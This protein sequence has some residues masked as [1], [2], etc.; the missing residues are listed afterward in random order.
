MANC[1]RLH[2]LHYYLKDISGLR[3]KHVEA[4]VKSWREDGLSNKTIQNNYSRLKIFCGWLGKEGIA[5]KDGAVHYLEEMGASQVDLRVKTVTDA[6][7]S[8]SGNGIDVIE[9]I[10]I[11]YREDYVFG[12]MME[13]GLAFG[14]RR[15]EQLKIKPWAADKGNYLEL[16]GSI[17]KGGRYRAM[18]FE[19][20][21]LGELQKATLAKVKKWCKKYQHLGWE[22]L[23]Y[24]AKCAHPPKFGHFV[25]LH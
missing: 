5:S 24:E 19:E 10:Q 18:P 17:T 12:L 1:G 2:K 23:T 13:M 3:E 25:K 7:K 8:W 14:L 16:D 6:S 4:L 20:G 9:K 21:E 15:K 11:A 22:G